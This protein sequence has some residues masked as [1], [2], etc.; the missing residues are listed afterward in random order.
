MHADKDQPRR[1]SG[2]LSTEDLAQQP[3]GAPA[4]ETEEQR[5]GAR[6]APVY[7]GESTG[8]VRREQTPDR[9]RTSGGAR[10]T[11]GTA[12]GT[13]GA[14]DPSA[15]RERP[16]SR[17]GAPDTGRTDAATGSAMDEPATGDG[18]TDASAAS[19]GTA[20]DEGEAAPRLLTPEDEQGFRERWHEIQSQFVDDPREAVHTADALVADVMQTLAATFSRHKQELESQWS[21]GERVDTE[22]LRK[23]LRHYRSFFNRLLST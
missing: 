2:G 11:S 7:P 10:D 20:A 17:P 21:Q 12:P 15:A 22:D 13:E 4:Q 3:S 5:T 14:A 9:D 23:A 18:R 8:T 16:D 6:R 1:F 19:T